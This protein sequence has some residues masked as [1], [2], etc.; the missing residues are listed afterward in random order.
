MDLF[1]RLL[2]RMGFRPPTA[3]GRRAAGR[4]GASGGVRKPRTARARSQQITRVERS[5]TT[6]WLPSGRRKRRTTSEWRHGNC[7]VRHRSEQAAA[8]CGRS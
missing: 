5:V 3:R 4:T 2:S 1:A 7:P 6:T 8:R